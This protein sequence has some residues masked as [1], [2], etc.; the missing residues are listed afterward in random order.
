MAK[1]NFFIVGCAKS[2]TT[3]LAKVIEQHPD[4]YMSPVKEPNFFNRKD[5]N[6]YSVIHAKTEEQYLSLFNGESGQKAVG[7][8]SPGYLHSDTAAEEI[9][10]FSTRAKIIIILRHPADLVCSWYHHA[11]YMGDD[12]SQDIHTALTTEFESQ[13]KKHTHK[14]YSYLDVISLSERIKRFYAIFP[15]D[16]IHL[17]MLEAM[18]QEPVETFRALFHFL[19]IDPGF[20]PV[21]D[22]HNFSR[23]VRFQAMH[24]GLT[25]LGLSPA[26]MRNNRLFKSLARILGPN[27]YTKLIGFGRNLYT[28]KSSYPAL[29]PELRKHL[30]DLLATE[31]DTLEKV[32][33]R[34]LSYWKQ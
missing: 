33:K 32:I 2:G 16:N 7:E 26:D 13:G 14:H 25:A 19:E 30:L 10:D 17:V 11:K 28:Q 8:A 20:T 9:F 27:L 23:K 31:T 4:I 24:K 29:S 15:H 12:N 6:Q 1:P 22:N 21:L 34:D 5:G 18:K 3:T